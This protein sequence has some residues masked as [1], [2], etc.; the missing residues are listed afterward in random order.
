MPKDTSIQIKTPLP[1]PVAQAL[2]ARD[3]QFV[4]PSYTRPYPLVAHEARGMIVTD[5]DGNQ[6]LD[7]SSGIAVCA[8]GHC[9]PRI[10]SAIQQQAARLIHM[11]GTDFY[12]TQMVDLAEKLTAITP[13]EYPKKVAFGNSGTEAIEAA[14]KLARYAT[15]RSKFIAF[16][17]S[18]HGRTMG[19][20]S[21]TASKPMQRKGFGPLL[22]GVVHVPFP[23]AYRCPVPHANGACDCSLRYIEEVLFKS[24]LNPTEVAAIVF[25]PI[26]GEGGYIV[27]PQIFFDGLK[28][29][30][31]KYGILLIADEVQSGM[32]R[33]GRMFAVDHFDC[34]PDIIAIAK[35]I[36]SGLPLGAIIAPARL[37]NWEP[38]AHASTFGGNPVSCAAALETIQLLEE[39]LIQNAA[40]MG[41]FLLRHLREMAR[42][43]DMIGEVR[44]LGLMI[45]IELVKE[46]STKEKADTWRNAVVQK[47]FEKGLLIL[48]C[49]ENTLRL[50]PPLIVNQDQAE[51]ALSIV[52][53]AIT[54]VEKQR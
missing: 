10:V 41:D 25:E 28:Q 29:I 35:G 4:S 52:D 33:T 44:G 48:G 27:A 26:Q 11:S 32:G 43:H 38:G 23:N 34:I 3:R 46:R 13:G 54:T 51:V 21:L 19:S 31:S 47:A 39:G 17:N 8:T 22:E 14:L 2:L 24:I 50:M 45:G 49:G 12:Y 36:A 7:F 15:G 40:A 37:M 5:V 18:F 20:L 53:E 30:A 1:G 42:R 6:F 9:H 16:F